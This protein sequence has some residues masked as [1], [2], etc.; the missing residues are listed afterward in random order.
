MKQSIIIACCFISIF[1]SIVVSANDSITVSFE[2]Y[3][4]Q[5]I[6]EER[7]GTKVLNSPLNEQ[8]PFIFSCVFHK[9]TYKGLIIHVQ[10][11]ASD[12]LLEIYLLLVN[13]FI[14]NGWSL[15]VEKGI[16]SATKWFSSSLDLITNTAHTSLKCDEFGLVDDTMLFE[17]SGKQTLDKFLKSIKD[18]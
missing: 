10:V 7:D 6:L 18:I 16:R 2:N 4:P 1:T 3:P 17:T 9:E 15:D 5:Q 12:N 14:N 13:T 8:W 11:D